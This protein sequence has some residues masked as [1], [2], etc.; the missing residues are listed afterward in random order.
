[1]TSN[2]LVDTPR[3]TTEPR[4][5]L[6]EAVGHL[7]AHSGSPF[8]CAGVYELQCLDGPRHFTAMLTAHGGGRAQFC[9]AATETELLLA[10]I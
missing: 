2:Q 8:H 9:G 10:T 6:A 5:D 3:S 7:L 4:P 1:M